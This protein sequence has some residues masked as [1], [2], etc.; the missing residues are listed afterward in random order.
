MDASSV[1]PDSACS[2]ARLL[3]AREGTVIETLDISGRASF[4][5]GR[6]DTADFPLM[7]ESCSRQHARVFWSA[8]L[9]GPRLA[10]ADL[11]SSHGT[12]IGRG[13]G[14][15]RLPANA[16]ALLAEGV[17]VSFGDSARQYT[18]IGL[19][20]QEVAAGMRASIPAVAAAGVSWG[21][22]DAEA[23]EEEEEEE[24]GG[25]EERE[26]VP[27]RQQ[28]YLDSLRDGDGERDDEDSGRLTG[29]KT[30]FLS[31][32]GGKSGVGRVWAGPYGWLD[33]LPTASLTE[34]ESSEVDRLRARLLRAKNLRTECDRIQAKE[35]QGLTEGQ[36]AQLSRNEA[37]LATLEGETEA[38]GE[39]LRDRLEARRPGCTGR[40]AAAAEGGGGKPSVALGHD[41][42]LT[43][44][45]DRLIDRTGGGVRGAGTRFTFKKGGV[46]VAV[47]A[48]PS[49]PVE[50]PRS[51]Q[52]RKVETAVSLAEA[53]GEVWVQRA[54]LEAAAHT[55]AAAAPRVRRGGAVEGEE[56]ELDAIV[57]ES[58]SA[59]AQASAEARDARLRALEEEEERLQVL[60]RA[61]A[62]ATYALDARVAVR[63]AAAAAAAEGGGADL[64]PAPPKRA[65]L[66]EEMPAAAPA[67]AVATASRA[68][69][70]LLSALQGAGAGLRP[71]VATDSS[72]LEEHVKP[73]VKAGVG[74][75][76]Y[77]SEEVIDATSF[78]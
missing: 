14:K 40:A 10:I 46:A 68:L 31:M 76:K 69:G 28:H 1:N 15:R 26:R 16:P 37:L 73:T 17:T 24:D 43:E 9:A 6:S 61:A 72:P 53:L 74:R 27:A 25:K 70:G 49:R 36:Q 33:A 50:A 78:S 20:R 65:R 38:A 29:N 48:P 59:Q 18:P 3:V 39:A 64:E 60:L 75:P 23:G 67:P 56:D 66:Q 5:L 8:S 12:F 13:S 51:R 54:A 4:T 45:D 47:A 30:A 42:T 19:P 7:H 22:L 57:R 44:E 63:R 41:R 77:D 55:A 52:T 62:P 32:L 71:A 2:A 34:K 35:A 11:G 58:S 21:V